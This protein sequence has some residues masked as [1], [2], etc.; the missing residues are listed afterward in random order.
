MTE[1]NPIEAFTKPGVFSLD[2]F[3]VDTA[4]PVEE[5]T[6]FTDAYSVNEYLKLADEKAKVE[7]KIK[8]ANL[9][10]SEAQR[11]H[12]RTVGGDTGPD[13]LDTHDLEILV[14]ELDIKMAEWDEKV[15]KSGIVFEVRGMPP[16]IVDTI[17]AKYFTDRKKDYSNTVEEDERDFELI[18]KSIIKVTGPDG[19]A[20]T[21]FDVD[22]VKI[23]KAKLVDGQ[24]MKLVGVVAHVNL[25]GALFDQATDASFLS[26]RSNLAH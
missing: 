21:E 11:N 19:S 4:Y 12:A 8:D 1:E 16:G 24:Y 15:S 7:Q 22:D 14:Q 13:L 20:T 26:R 2:N 25:N 9:L 18:A 17:S 23:L 6:V 10:N 3:L 5:V